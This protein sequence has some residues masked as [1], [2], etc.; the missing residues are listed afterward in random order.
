MKGKGYTPAEKGDTTKWHAPGLFDK[1]TGS[2]I[3]G[4]GNK[5]EAIKTLTKQKETTKSPPAKE[6]E[7]IMLFGIVKV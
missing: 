3:K 2:I 5:S 6:E 4:N 7:T 1:K